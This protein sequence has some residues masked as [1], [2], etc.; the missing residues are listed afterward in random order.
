VWERVG[1]RGRSGYREDLQLRISYLLPE[2]SQC[3]GPVG[4]F[5]QGAIR[6]AQRSR[7]ALRGYDAQFE[8]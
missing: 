2:P 8:N 6:T 4:T 5:T 3:E 1:V 7:V